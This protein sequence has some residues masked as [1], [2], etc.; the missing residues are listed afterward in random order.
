MS[1]ATSISPSKGRDRDKSTPNT[2]VS[3]AASLDQ[4]PATDKPLFATSITLKGA[5]EKGGE[6]AA[7]AESGEKEQ[8]VPTTTAIFFL[9]AAVLSSIVECFDPIELL[10]FEALVSKRLTVDV[11]SSNPSMWSKAIT[12]ALSS[13]L[14]ARAYHSGKGEG[15]GEQRFPDHAIVCDEMMD[16][17]FFT[18]DVPSTTTDRRSIPIT[19]KWE[20]MTRQGY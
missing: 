11:S 10:R 14:F 16:M 7:A 3:S 17:S 5:G 18:S 1:S 4:T 2:S 13:Y 15:E 6:V 20:M 19:W 8:K 9:P 12:Q